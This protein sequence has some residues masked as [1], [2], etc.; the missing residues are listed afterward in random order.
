MYSV[1]VILQQRDL[2]AQ[3]AILRIC[4]IQ[5]SNMCGIYSVVS[6]YPVTFVTWQ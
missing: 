1:A 5:R 6:W 2:L 3:N 4:A